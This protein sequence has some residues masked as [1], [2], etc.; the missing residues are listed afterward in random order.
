MDRVKKKPSVVTFL[1]ICA[2]VFFIFTLVGMTILMH[3]A[4][5]QALEDNAQRVLAKEV[6]NVSRH[7]VISDADAIRDLDPEDIRIA[8]TIRVET[9]G[10]YAAVWTGQKGP[11]AGI[12]PSGL[13]DTIST[14]LV[15]AADD[16]MALQ[17][18]RTADGT[19]YAC[20]QKV[21][22]FWLGRDPAEADP[23]VDP[24]EAIASG[25][26]LDLHDGAKE[27]GW[28]PVYVRTIIN[29]KDMD[30]VYGA[31]QRW[32]V[33]FILAMV[34]IM[35]FGGLILYRRAS[36]PVSEMY[37]QARRISESDDMTGHL[38]DTG[39]FRETQVMTEAYNRLIGRAHHLVRRQEEFNENVSHELR[40]PVAIIRS[41]CELIE[42][43][44]RDDMPEE[45]R[46]A[47][48]VIRRQS[49][50]MN[51]MIAELLHLSRM[52]RDGY[53]L[54]R[55]PVDLVD[56]AESAGE[57][58]DYKMEGRWR[59]SYDLEP[60]EAEIDVTLIMIAIRNLISNAMKYSPEGSC[61]RIRTG[62]R[63]KTAAVFLQIEDEG[64]GISEEN[65]KRI[66]D[67]YYQVQAER[68]SDGFGLGL[69]LVKKIV[70]KHGGHVEVVSA[71]DEGSSF[72]M[73][74]PRAE[75]GETQ[76]G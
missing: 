75:R 6:R 32:Y 31:I 59:F 43:M 10:C 25:G 11:L 44:Y 27:E 64:I 17:R 50:R 29:V 56:L 61:I 26:I 16:D 47:V 60:A 36:R 58:A 9:E 18:F 39:N 8:S 5:Y 19:F 30:T 71:L 40:T 48:A 69:P 41:E 37:D 74:L 66:F 76:E 52:D 54:R 34:C 67:P 35:G 2:A 62:S 72:T 23:P 38:E 3:Y 28:E 55:E 24:D 20:D 73:V 1:S 45:V 22:M 13:T 7:L 21:R 15:P 57:D 65:Q 46:D 4:T 70:E 12:Y 33:F 68:S 51:T 63:E 14:H 42:D 49:D 53:E